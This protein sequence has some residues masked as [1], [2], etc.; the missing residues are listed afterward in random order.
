MQ[1][2]VHFLSISAGV[3][4]GGGVLC[5][6]LRPVSIHTSVQLELSSLLLL[7]RAVITWTGG[8]EA[9]RV[10]ELQQQRQVAQGRQV[11][12]VKQQHPSRLRTER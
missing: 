1:L 4:G 3:G 2:K 5:T 10:E 11:D 12:S 6:T 8:S 7:L 9:A